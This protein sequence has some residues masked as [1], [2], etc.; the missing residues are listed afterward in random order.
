M[1]GHPHLLDTASSPQ[2]LG[3]LGHGWKQA[4]RAHL[5]TLTLPPTLGNQGGSWSPEKTQLFHFWGPGLLI[6]TTPRAILG[7]NGLSPLRWP[8]GKWNR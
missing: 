1:A 3:K 2:G 6:L 7:E 5:F 8:P 4:H